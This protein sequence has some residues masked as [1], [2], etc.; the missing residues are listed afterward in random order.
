MGCVILLWHS[1]S[2]PYNHFDVQSL[3]ISLVQLAHSL[4]SEYT[5]RCWFL[6]L[7]GYRNTDEYR[8]YFVQCPI[9]T[10]IVYAFTE[11]FGAGTVT[12]YRISR[13]LKIL[14]YEI[15][16]LDGSLVY[17]TSGGNFSSIHH[18]HMSV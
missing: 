17:R 12:Y 16:G 7:T 6:P 15:S 3:R 13:N 8:L 18:A 9:F 1:L 11:F 10:D 4:T 2:F 5:K 14:Q